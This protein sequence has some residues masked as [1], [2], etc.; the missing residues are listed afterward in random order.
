VHQYLILF[1]IARILRAS[2]AF[3]TEWKRDTC[4]F[5]PELIWLLIRTS[6]AA[7]GL[8][9]DQSCQQHERREGR[10]HGCK[11]QQDQRPELLVDPPSDI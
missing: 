11:Q 9:T 2:I 3:T 1:P 7:L 4:R 6:A 8:R 10:N 5:N